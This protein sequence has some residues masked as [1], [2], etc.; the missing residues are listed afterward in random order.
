MAYGAKRSRTK[1]HDYIICLQNNKMSEGRRSQKRVQSNEVNNSSKIRNYK[2]DEA[3]YVSEKEMNTH[4]D[5][6]RLIGSG[7]IGIMPTCC[8][9]GLDQIKVYPDYFF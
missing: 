3:A 8:D 7:D 9:F 5:K 4:R 2:R 1:R 6:Q